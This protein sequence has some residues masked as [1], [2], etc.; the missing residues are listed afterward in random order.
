MN[1]D[2]DLGPCDDPA[3]HDWERRDDL[4]CELCG[5]SHLGWIC[6]RCWEVVDG[7]FYARPDG[8]PDL[9]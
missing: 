2:P 1:P 6:R 8:A 9:H 3:G 5:P 4:G 7:T